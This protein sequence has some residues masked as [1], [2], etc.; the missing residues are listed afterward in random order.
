MAMNGFRN[1]AGEVGYRFDDRHRVSLSIME[2]RLTERHLRSGWESAAVDGAGVS[3]YFRNYEL[4]ATRRLWRGAYLSLAAGYA[5]DRYVHGE[6]GDEISNHTA[7][8]GL[9]LGWRWD[10]PFSIP[11]SYVDL[12]IPARYYVDPIEE[13]QLGD[14]TVRSHTLVNNIW[15]FVGAHW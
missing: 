5:H 4:H 9:G 13:T 15:L 14:A 11:H 8:A 6:S 12:S 3:G 7:T 10:D 1:F 2:V